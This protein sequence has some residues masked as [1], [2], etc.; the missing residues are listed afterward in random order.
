M[1]ATRLTD[2]AFWTNPEP[3][4]AGDEGMTAWC[5]SV[6]ELEGHVLFQ[7]SGSSGTP[8]WIALS[9]TALQLSAATVNRHLQVDDSTC[10]GL[11]LPLHHVGGF[12]VVA[13]AYEAACRLAVFAGKWEAGRFAEWCEA[14]KVTHVSLVPTQVFDLVQ[15]GLQAP[16]TLK[17]IVVG[18]GRLEESVG[19]AARRLGWPVL[20]S[21]GMTETG[22]QIATQSLE[23]LEPPYQIAPLPVLDVWQVSNEK[24]GRLFVA[25]PALF[26]GSITAT[27][28]VRKWLPRTC[29]WYATSDRAFI[30]GR[31]ITPLGRMDSVVKVLGELVDPE[32]IERELVRLSDDHLEVGS[33]AVLAVPDQRT[34][35]RLIPVFEEAV[36]VELMTR[37][38]M[39]YAASAPGFR[40][41]S[42]PV[43]VEAI[44]R[45]DLGK[46]LRSELMDF[47]T[48]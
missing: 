21:Y 1:D 36:P 20:A 11:T 22:S 12:G 39:A 10:W 33:F 27:D 40:R 35:H 19:R 32:A 38:L 6:D 30:R 13:R 7:T 28:G 2:P 24:D 41:L 48:H 29:E 9:K 45:S 15:A 34:E 23:L 25:G 14:S 31:E 3:L 4:A 42:M 18:G 44:P 47:L 5:R 37:T 17:V 46:I 8:K 16:P 26:T 43:V